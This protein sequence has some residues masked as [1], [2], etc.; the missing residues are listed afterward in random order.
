MTIDKKPAV[1]NTTV[2]HHPLCYRCEHRAIYLETGHAPRCECGGTG[3]VIGCYM[4]RPVKP[5]VTCP[6]SGDKRPQYR[7]WMFSG[8]M[9]GIRIADGKYKLIESEGEN[10]VY[11]VPN[12]E[13]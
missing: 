7:G 4:Y 9:K 11:F 10:A 3:A 2:D 8:R 13:Q 12:E 6:R 5:V 1:D